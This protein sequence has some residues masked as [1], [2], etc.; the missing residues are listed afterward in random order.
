MATAELILL[1]K[2]LLSAGQP[3]LSLD[4]QSWRALT[5][6]LSQ[7]EREVPI[8]LL[9]PE[10]DSEPALDSEIAAGPGFGVRPVGGGASPAPCSPKPLEGV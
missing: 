4:P 5:P 3:R 2:P 6:T 7:R 8:T 1:S 10:R 9:R